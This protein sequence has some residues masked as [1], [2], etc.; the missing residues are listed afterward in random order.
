MYPDADC[1]KQSKEKF[2]DARVRL[3]VGW[4]AFL[5]MAGAGART[6]QCEFAV[7]MPLEAVWPNIPVEQCSLPMSKPG[8]KQCKPGSFYIHMLK[9]K[10][11]KIPRTAPKKD[12]L[13]HST[14]GR[15]LLCATPELVTLTSG[16]LR[17]K[18]LLKAFFHMQSHKNMSGSWICYSGLMSLARSHCL[19]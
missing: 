1:E 8:N 11:H 10:S 14:C 12:R 7:A 4:S 19:K 16:Y 6:P 17:W 3:R 13:S 2:Q 9:L 18:I 15:V 5:W